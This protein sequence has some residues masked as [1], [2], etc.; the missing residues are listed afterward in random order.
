MGN[1]KKILLVVKWKERCL[2]G[3]QLTELSLRR[4]RYRPMRLMNGAAAGWSAP[5]FGSADN[6]QI[7]LI[8]QRG[9]SMKRD[10][11]TSG[12]EGQVE[13][14][15]RA[16][17]KGVAKYFVSIRYNSTLWHFLA[18]RIL[19]LVTL[20]TD[21][22][23][24]PGLEGAQRAPLPTDSVAND[25]R[26]KQRKQ[27]LWC[28][29][30]ADLREMCK[31]QDFWLDALIGGKRG[32][33]LLNGGNGENGRRNVQSHAILENLWCFILHLSWF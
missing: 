18:G 11:C 27:P 10:H 13:T 17:C 25:M 22:C 1:C 30:C 26:T 32:L 7:K 12:P 16:W 20:M 3:G 2:C 6:E 4:M 14:V 28:A 33:R 5:L 24:A 9:R 15:L 8:N 19:W 29:K 23:T 21:L 31:L